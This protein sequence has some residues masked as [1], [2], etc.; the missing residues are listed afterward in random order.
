MLLMSIY[1]CK[2]QTAI[3][4][5]VKDQP[6]PTLFYKTF[7]ELG[8]AN[9]ATALAFD[10]R[11]LIQLLGD[12]F[13]HLFTEEY[14]IFYRNKI[15]KGPVKNGKFFYR[16]AIETAVRLDQT[17]AVEAIINYLVKYQNN[18]ITSWLFN[19][20]LPAIIE[21]GINI[22]PLLKSK[23]FNYT[24]DFDE[25]PSQ[26]TDNNTQL[27][28]YNHSIFDIRNHYRKVFHEEKFADQVNAL[29]DNSKAD[30]GQVYKI[31]YTLNLLPSF[32]EH[33]E[34]GDK[35]RNEPDTVCN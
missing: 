30:S 19:R 8:G 16:N 6:S 12:Q 25:W 18:F 33:I 28:S 3:V 10:S 11:S 5:L 17:R 21:K 34:I 1:V 2:T 26:H 14:P 31:K 22:T 27:R 15:Q 13:Q 7:L 35:M 20:P 4:E 29:T 23:I 24:F 32:G 9:M